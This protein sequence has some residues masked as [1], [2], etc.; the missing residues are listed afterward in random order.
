MAEPGNDEE[1]Y[2]LHVVRA[3]HQYGFVR[4]HRLGRRQP[5][6]L[7]LWRSARRCESADVDV[8]FLDSDGVRGCRSRLSCT[9]RGLSTPPLAIDTGGDV[10]SWRAIKLSPASLIVDSGAEPWPYVLSAGGLDGAKH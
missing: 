4:F 2:P 1:T 7:R 10:D 6:A 3:D 5:S 9:H 8:F